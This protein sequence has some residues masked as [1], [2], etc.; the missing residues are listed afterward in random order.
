[1]DP[2]WQLYQSLM[3]DE[4]VGMVGPQLRYGDGEWQNSRRRL[5]TPLTGFWES[6]WLGQLW[7]NNPW[8]RA[9][10]M[11]DWPSAVAHDVDW[12]TGAAMFARRSALDAVCKPADTGPF[13]ERFFMYSEELDLCH[14][15][16]LGGWRIVY[17]P[18]VLVLH[19]E[20]RSSEQ[21]VAARHIRFNS[22]KVYYY[23]KY[24]GRGW[25]LVLR[26]YLLLEF[27]LQL[28]IEWLKLQLGHHPALR[29]ARIAAYQ[30]V[31]QSQLSPVQWAPAAHGAKQQIR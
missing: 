22:S 10:H 3:G 12:L 31:L 6:T 1:M 19:Y 23:Q 13:D 7:P 9:Y 20:G 17:D 18:T 27:R 28:L 24:F 8:A 21:V 4:T 16:R 2:L 14:R 5:P 15:L 30:Q 29:R 11:L 25:A 26:R